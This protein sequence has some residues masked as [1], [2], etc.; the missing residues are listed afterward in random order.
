MLVGAWI[1]YRVP[2]SVLT[3]NQQARPYPH[4][5]CSLARKDVAIQKAHG[6]AK[7]VTSRSRQ[8]PWL[9]ASQ[10]VSRSS[11][12]LGSANGLEELRL[13]AVWTPGR[14]AMGTRN[15]SPVPVTF[16]IPSW[17]RLEAPS[18]DTGPLSST[19]KAKAR[20][21]PKTNKVGLA[22]TLLLCLHCARGRPR[23][24]MR[25]P[26]EGAPDALKS[27]PSE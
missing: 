13:E 17:L 25:T 6:A 24:W 7:V 9:S 15:R 8:E 26:W 18:Q 23:Q 12:R 22:V 16:A 10:M 27:S 1:A 14:N 21:V 20:T 3:E 4:R 5:A 19:Q 2:A 11:W